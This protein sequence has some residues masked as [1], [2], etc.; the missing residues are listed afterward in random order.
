MLY[1]DGRQAL[2]QAAAAAVAE[3][4]IEAV[5]TRD[6]CARAG[7]GAPTLYHH[8]GSRDGLLQQLLRD[9]HDRYLAGKDD[10]AVT[11]N[12]V[13]DTRSGWDHH[14]AFAR[15]Q[16]QLYPLLLRPGSETSESSLT[17]LRAGF[18]RL[19]QQDVLRR[20]ITAAQATIVLS[21][22]LRGIAM[23]ISHAPDD[24]ELL[25]ASELLRDA[26]IDALLTSD[27]TRSRP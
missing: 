12:P 18:D 8:F 26:V 16:A 4:G 15:S 24:A 6:V 21:S 23:R 5:T 3:H 13:A 22:A 25:Y 2:L 7:V 10:I 14:I 19:E 20:A 17:R 11:G 27:T 9:V 1:G